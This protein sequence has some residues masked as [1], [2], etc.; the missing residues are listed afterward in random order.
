MFYDDTL[1]GVR[2]S[3]VYVLDDKVAVSSKS[4]YTSISTGEHRLEL[5]KLVE[6]GPNDSGC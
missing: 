3:R 2:V 6:G 5:R 4:R 1:G